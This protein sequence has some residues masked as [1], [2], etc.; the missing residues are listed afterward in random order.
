M[1][2]GL[3]IIMGIRKLLSSAQEE[4]KRKSAKK[5]KTKLNIY[6]TNYPRN[7]LLS[8]R[9]TP[10]LQ[11][12]KKVRI[13]IHVMYDFANYLSRKGYNVDLY[14]YKF[15]YNIDYQNYSLL[16]GFGYP[17]ENSFYQANR[18]PKR[19]FIATGAHSSQRNTAE[20]L[21]LKYLY[22]RRG[23]LLKPRRTK[24][25][26][27]SASSILSDALISIGTDW[28]DSTYHRFFTKTIYR[29]PWS[30]HHYFPPSELCRDYSDAK[31]H[32]LWIGSHG[33][34][35]KGLDLCLEAFNELINCELHV[36]APKEDDFFHA[37][38]SELNHS[39]NIHYHG[40]ISPSSMEF[41]EI[42]ETCA[43]V[44]SP[45]CSEG[46][47]EA[48]LTAM[49]TGLIPVVSKQAAIDIGDFGIEIET[50][51]VSSV[52]AAIR[53]ATAFDNKTLEQLSMKTYSNTI[54]HHSYTN[55]KRQ[56]EQVIDRIA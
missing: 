25:F 42:C 9:V 14:D 43:F 12:L 19:I 55:L 10:D 44:L 1:S 33:L 6:N 5:R 27:D 8:W 3:N 24:G 16:I 37:Y 11:R 49:F 2:K 28:T 51:E 46:G 17:F 13:S 48:C 56:M 26:P 22:N 47:G 34:V 4:L 45:S 41:Q 40:F 23:F 21:Q 50:L 20:I 32:F 36:F 15:N 52:V 29:I 30:A 53:K 54:E 39:K 7:A 31:Y 18:T 38:S 35:H